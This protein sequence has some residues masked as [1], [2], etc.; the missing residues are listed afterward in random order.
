M[1][2]I[3]LSLGLTIFAADVL[4]ADIKYLA[5][6]GQDCS[7]E[8]EESKL[9]SVLSAQF[10]AQLKTFNEEGSENGFKDRVSQFVFC[11]E[12]VS[13]VGKILKKEGLIGFDFEPF[14][15]SLSLHFFALMKKGVKI[16][17]EKGNGFQIMFNWKWSGN[18][19][20]AQGDVIAL[21]PSQEVI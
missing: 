2:Q 17:E 12:C 11:P 14:Q 15:K 4:G 19:Y 20:G 1:I 5:F 13:C 3:W 10:V 9:M 8:V 21:N 16:H 6:D 7:A 18:S